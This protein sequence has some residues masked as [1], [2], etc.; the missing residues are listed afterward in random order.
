M[1]KKRTAKAKAAGETIVYAN[2]ARY[3]HL[4][5]LG[6]VA[7]EPSQTKALAISGIGPRR[8]A[9]HAP[10]RP[11]LGPARMAKEG[12]ARAKFESKLRQEIEKRLRRR[13]RRQ[14]RPMLP[15]KS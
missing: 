8:R 9:R 6:H 5:E 7:V 1:G 3:V 15:G 11:F 12:E 2:P 13:L 10:A 4:V 14:S